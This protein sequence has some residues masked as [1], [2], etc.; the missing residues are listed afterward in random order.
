[1]TITIEQVMA[2][3]QKASEAA[4]AFR[5]LEKEYAKQ[6]CPLKIGETTKVTGF[7][8]RGKDMIVERI[9]PG[10]IGSPFSSKGEWVAKGH[11]LKKDGSVGLHVGEVH[12]KN[13][14]PKLPEAQ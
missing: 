10:D 5:R 7:S 3:K 13:Y 4:E 9:I 2:E 8:H 12:A 11:I 14:Q 6:Q 1:M